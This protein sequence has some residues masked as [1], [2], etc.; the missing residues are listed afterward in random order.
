MQDLLLLLNR[1]L[2]LIWMESLIFMVMQEK[3]RKTHSGAH[4]HLLIILTGQVSDQLL[5]R[6]LRN[7][8][9]AEQDQ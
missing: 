5:F 6:Q 9:K 8:C 4:F 1:I 2:H 7:L 3:Q